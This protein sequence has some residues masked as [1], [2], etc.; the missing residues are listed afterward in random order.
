VSRLFLTI[1]LE[2]ATQRRTSKGFPAGNLELA[3]EGVRA[4]RLSGFLI[5]VHVRIHVETELSEIVELIQFARS[6]DV[7]GLVVSPAHGGLN[8][9]NPDNAMVQRKT[10]EARKLSGSKWWESFSRLVEPV[11]SGERR[12]QPT[13]KEA[14][15]RLEQEERTNE[16]GVRVA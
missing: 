11:V 13:G 4:A 1:R 12:A 3:A 10:A 2:P 14:S 6:Q 7:D 15:V 8:S 5:C 9:A 16:E